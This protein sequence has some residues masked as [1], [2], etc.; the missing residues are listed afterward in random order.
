MFA[1]FVEEMRGIDV[2]GV[3]KQVHAPDYTQVFQVSNRLDRDVSGFPEISV[4]GDVV[5]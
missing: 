5:R 1:P 2:L 4:D 3:I